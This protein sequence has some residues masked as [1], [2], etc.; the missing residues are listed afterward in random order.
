MASELSFTSEG[1][2]V[3]PAAKLGKLKGTDPSQLR[4]VDLFDDLLISPHPQPGLR[5][6]PILFG[7]LRLFHVAD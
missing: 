1:G 5:P 7:D 4:I 6:Q 3:I 2:L